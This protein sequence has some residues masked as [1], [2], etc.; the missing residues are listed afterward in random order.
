MKLDKRPFSSIEE[1]DNKIIEWWNKAV[2]HEDEVWILGDISFHSAEKTIEIFNSLNGTKRLVVGNHDRKLLKNNDVRELFAEIVD[3]KELKLEDGTGI[4]LS[5][6]PIPFYNHNNH[7]W[8]HLYGRLHNDYTYEELEKLKDSMLQNNKQELR[9]YNVGCML[10]YMNYSPKT[11]EEIINGYGEIKER[12]KK[13]LQGNKFIYGLADIIASAVYLTPEVSIDEIIKRICP[14]VLA[15]G[16]FVSNQK[17]RVKAV[18]D[19]IKSYDVANY[20]YEEIKVKEQ[21]LY[22]PEKEIQVIY[23]KFLSIHPVYLIYENPYGKYYAISDIHGYLDIL[24]DT[25]KNISLKMND[26]LFFLGDYIDGGPHSRQTLEYLYNLQKRFPKNV[27]ILKGNHEELFL[28]WLADDIEIGFLQEDKGLNTIKTFLKD[29]QLAIIADY[30][31]KGKTL[32][33]VNSIVKK[34]IKKNYPELIEWIKA[35]PL[36]YE[37]AYNIFVH[38]GIDEDAW[39]NWTLTTEDYV[40]TQKY[41]HTTGKFYKDIIAGHIGVSEIAGDK[42]FHDIYFDGENHYYIDSTVEISRK[43]NLLV[44]D[45]ETGEYTFM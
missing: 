7:G 17:N 45:T 9:M 21:E 19:F 35:M 11:L 32:F 43:L 22:R 25:V 31:K 4:V 36:Y 40:Y 44:Y 29:N 16:A 39:D 13:Y 6:N 41:P 10:S 38:A 15:F 20:T 12:R 18:Y 34:Y 26:K 5:H 30:L 37:T 24:H 2:Q 42:N 3:Y 8:Y 28:Q 23:D 33:E 14:A 27:V 1:H